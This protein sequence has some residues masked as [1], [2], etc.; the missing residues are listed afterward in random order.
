[1]KY[2]YV[3]LTPLPP[4]R[5]AKEAERLD[6]FSQF[7]FKM[8]DGEELVGVRL[9]WKRNDDFTSYGVVP[10]ECPIYPIL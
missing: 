2:Y 4:E 8:Y 10:V 3:D 6:A 7:S 1:M 5:R 9:C